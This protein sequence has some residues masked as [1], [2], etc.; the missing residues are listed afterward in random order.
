MLSTCWPQVTVT[1]M[2]VSPWHSKFFCGSCR[3]L[4]VPWSSSLKRHWKNSR[5]SSSS[6]SSLWPYQWDRERQN[7]NGPLPLAWE[8]HVILFG[9]HSWQQEE[10][11]GTGK[12]KREK[13]HEIGV[14]KMKGDSGGLHV[15]Q[16][17]AVVGLRT[18]F[19]CLSTHI[20]L[21]PIST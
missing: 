7:S 3:C 11:G 15:L 17:W 8:K 9:Q 2:C 13:K 12:I 4:S 19:P 10:T 14:R 6:S 18:D 20:L 5:S 16:S 1:S 21:L